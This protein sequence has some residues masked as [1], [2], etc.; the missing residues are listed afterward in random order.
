MNL[1]NDNE[2]PFQEKLPMLKAAPLPS[3][4]LESRVARLAAPHASRR[5]LKLGLTIGGLVAAGAL[6]SFIFAP[7]IALAQVLVAASNS[8]STDSLHSTMTWIFNGKPG[9]RQEMWL[10]PGKR[11]TESRV[12]GA[13]GLVS[14][15]KD[16][17]YWLYQPGIKVATWQKSEPLESSPV[18]IQKLHE[19]GA[20]LLRRPFGVQDEGEVLQ[21][22]RRYHCF[23]QDQRA[24]GVFLRGDKCRSVA[25]VDLE[26][27][28]LDRMEVQALRKGAWETQIQLDY[29]W[30][31]PIAEGT[32]DTNFPNSKIYELDK[33][34]EEMG[35]R[36]E[37][38]IAV[39]KFAT[40]TIALRDVQVNAEGDVFVLFTDGSKP[41]GKPYKD[42]SVLDNPTDSLKR[43][44]ARTMG[45]MMPF[46]RVS[47]GKDRGLTIGGEIIDG[48]CSTLAK[49]LVG[50]WQPR[51]IEFSVHFNEQVGSKYYTRFARFSVPIARPKT[52]LLPDYAEALQILAL[53]GGEKTRFEKDR[54]SGRLSQAWNDR[55]WD[56]LL[57]L[58]QQS[59]K[60]YPDEFW[61]RLYQVRALRHL[62]RL[63]KAR[64]A[65]NAL[66]PEA[67]FNQR[68]ADEE[69]KALLRAEQGKPEPGD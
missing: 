13:P 33:F 7:Q 58:T 60:R 61:P 50:A 27:R 25:W 52:A 55:R 10:A 62:G 67:G 21:N 53:P 12:D 40:R 24:D 2:K 22:G 48:A 56:D 5:P 23:S 46:M 41:E 18:D 68:E 14:I 35:K 28:K 66:L 29:D 59:L 57:T 42:E 36:F 9:I 43:E 15:E 16:G 38:P 64:Q 49:P 8:L 69:A 63:P 45:G 20:R 19:E 31:H 11:R 4:A 34:G 37:K 44:Y 39:Q 26:K 32:F 1:D 3:N 65:L 51:T 47:N 54:D 30:E 6:A 17:K